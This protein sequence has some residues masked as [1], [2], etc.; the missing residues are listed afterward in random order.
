MSAGEWHDAEPVDARFARCL[1]HSHL[2]ASTDQ[3]QL[4]R[5]QYSDE[6]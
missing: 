6:D 4:R 2:I 1:P 3:L 5:G